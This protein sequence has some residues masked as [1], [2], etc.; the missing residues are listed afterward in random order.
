MV[1]RVWDTEVVAWA[2]PQC[3]CEK[4]FAYLNE[5]MG[6]SQVRPIYRRMTFSTFQKQRQPQAF[7]I[8]ANYAK[9][10][11]DNLKSGRGIIFHGPVGVGKTHLAAAIVNYGMKKHY[12]FCIIQSTP[13][14]FFHIRQQN[15]QFVNALMDCDLLVLDDFGRERATDFVQETLFTVINARYEKQKPVIIT[16]N[17]GPK[18]LRKNLGDAVISRLYEMCEI[19]NMQ[20]EDYRAHKAKSGKH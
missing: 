15:F 18:T 2:Q 8:A 20:G 6:Q 7:A 1:I 11:Q 3:D 16:T 9:N 10:I 5:H 14:M 12:L 19:V 13:E 4:K 17:I